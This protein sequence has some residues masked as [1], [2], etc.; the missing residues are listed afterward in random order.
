MEVAQRNQVE[1]FDFQINWKNQILKDNVNMGQCSIFACW[2]P[3][4]TFMFV[5]GTLPCLI[6]RGESRSNF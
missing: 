4:L 2:K 1:I 5:G 6:V 3:D